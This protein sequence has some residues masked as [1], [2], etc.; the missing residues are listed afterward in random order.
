MQQH[1]YD[2]VRGWQAADAGHSFDPHETTAWR[3]GYQLFLKRDRARRRYANMAQHT[4]A[5]IH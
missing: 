5:S 1:D 4:P 3:E 2:L